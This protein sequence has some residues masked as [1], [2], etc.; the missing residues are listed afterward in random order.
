MEIEKMITELD[1][2]KTNTDIRK[3]LS[4]S[5]ALIKNLDIK[6]NEKD[7]H[8][9]KTLWKLKNPQYCQAL[10]TT[11][12]KLSEQGYG[13]FAKALIKDILVSRGGNQGKL[14]EMMTYYCFLKEDV[15]FNPQPH[16]EAELCFKSSGDGYDADGEILELNCVFDVKEFGIGFPHIKDFKMKLQEQ[17]DRLF[18]EKIKEYLEESNNTI[19]RL[20]QE[21]DSETNDVLKN[22]LKEEIDKE[23]RKQDRMDSEINSKLW[24]Y[25][26]TVDGFINLGI[27][28][29]AD[30]IKNASCIAEKIVNKA[31]KERI[32]RWEEDS[33]WNNDNPIIKHGLGFQKE[34]IKGLGLTCTLESKIAQEVR[35][36]SRMN[37]YE[38]DAYEWAMKNRYYFMGDASQFVRNKPYMII[39]VL[40]RHDNMFL[41]DVN[42]YDI[43][44]RPL[45]RRM[46]IELSRMTDRNVQTSFDGKAKPGFSVSEAAKKIT[47]IIFLETSELL[48]TERTRTPM[49]IYLNPNADNPL[50]NNQVNRLRLMMPEIIEDYKYDNY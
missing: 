20:E 18:S 13:E 26:I 46:F 5:S 25:T 42:D 33:T 39:C 31:W 14:F 22:T 9:S 21:I 40:D 38:I 47:G 24:D 41:R 44:F 19:R 2:A 37:V 16:I 1:N 43:F 36:T 27:D 8:T 45:C 12:E 11:I 17:V 34:F 35:G 29:L 30:Y 50:L 15:R 48:D 49:W 32:N 4:E 7:I 6:F 28:E 3:I 23:K 10:I